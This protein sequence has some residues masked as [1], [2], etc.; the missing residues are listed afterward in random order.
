M[1]KRKDAGLAPARRRIRNLKLNK[2]IVLSPL[3]ARIPAARK[4]K[5]RWKHFLKVLSAKEK[6]VFFLLLISSACSLIYLA[7]SFYIKNTVEIASEGGIFIEA[8]VGQPRF[9]NPV[10]ANSDPDRDLTE[11]VFSGLMKYDKNMKII[12][13]LAE[14]YPSVENGERTYIFKIR[15]DALWHDGEK[16]TAD[17]IVFT[18][19]TIQNPAIK[20][21]YLANWVGVLAEKVDD[22]TVKFILQKPY[23]AFLENC[24]LKIIPKHI[25]EEIS[26]ESFA[27]QSYNLEE[28]VGSGLYRIKKVERNNEKVESVLLEKNPKFYGDKPYISAI[29]FLFFS[30]QEEAERAAEKGKANGF[31][32]DSPKEGWTETAVFLPRYFAV[33]FNSANS[34]ILKD[35]KI[36]Q[37]LAYGTD[38]SAFKKPASSPL[39]PEFY[40]F[41]IPS[42]YEYNLEM[43]QKL[44]EEMGY[45]DEDGNG[46]RE[47]TI[48]KE[49]SFSFKSRL[50]SGSQGNEVRELQRCLGIEET[51][52]FGEQTK[53]AVNQF[54][55]KYSEEILAP[56]GYSS[57]TGSVGP[58]T[59]EK[60]NEICFSKL[61]ETKELKITLATVDQPGMKRIAETLKSQWAKIGLNLEISAYPISQ[62]EQDIIRSRNYEALLFGEVLGAIPDPFPFWH[63]SQKNDPGLNLSSYEN[64]KVDELLED[65]R[66]SSDEAERKEKLEDF[67][68]I[69][70]QDIPAIF[71]YSPESLY[72]TSNVKGI[73]DKKAVN[74]SKR[75]L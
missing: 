75:F 40:G 47:L 12:P 48:E 63:S 53:I 49:P 62:L 21:P 51:G 72:L 27:F 46:I 70:I 11:L 67:Q 9:L 42:E 24:A 54:Q 32:S 50:S 26:S 33:F 28:A 43:A 30:S 7:R 34:G 15:Q 6:L 59:R 14:S 65:A 74:S 60:L 52:Y 1:L 58:S 36:R 45:K 68:E 4:P 8:S 29:K 17:D 10:Y 39:L 35:P 19:K 55:E 31:S 73:S 25:W 37:A 61:G 5:G 69:I 41:D 57:P 3:S 2:D 64:K 13:D 16:V 23:A 20:S 44:A 66:K 71:L 56:A 22:Y 18:V 38:K